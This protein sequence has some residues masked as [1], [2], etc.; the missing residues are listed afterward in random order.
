[1]D[2]SG[3]RVADQAGG[4]NQQAQRQPS[5]IASQ[6]GAL[7]HDDEL[8]LLRSADAW[9]TVGDDT[10]RN[11]NS[12][13]NHTTTTSSSPL[14]PAVFQPPPLS[15]PPSTAPVHPTL[16]Q[17]ELEAASSDP[18]SDFELVDPVPPSSVD[19]PAEGASRKYAYIPTALR[20]QSRKIRRPS[21]PFSDDSEDW[22]AARGARNTMEPANNYDDPEWQQAGPNADAQDLSGPGEHGKLECTVTK[23]QKEGEGTQNV[24]TSYLVTTDVCMFRRNNYHSH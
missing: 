17:P 18:D 1:M 20:G 6:A 15:P 24:Y 2:A 12:T 19:G 7:G 9:R 16:A 4:A 3:R 8:L 23:P 5:A 14:H 10:P 22:N 21:N 13:H 11:R